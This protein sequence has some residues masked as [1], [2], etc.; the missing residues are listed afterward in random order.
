MWSV[1]GAYMEAGNTEVITWE[2]D[3]FPENIKRE[4]RFGNKKGSRSSLKVN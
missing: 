4:F 2:G 1:C 3:S